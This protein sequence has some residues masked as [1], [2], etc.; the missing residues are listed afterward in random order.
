MCLTIPGKI[1]KISGKTAIIEQQ[2]KLRKI[3]LILLDKLK[4]GDWILVLNNMAVQKISGLE[5]KQIINLYKYEQ[6]K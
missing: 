3:N 2:N 5:A 6:N 1:K 4:I